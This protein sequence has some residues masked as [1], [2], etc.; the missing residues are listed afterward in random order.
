ME[1]GFQ[2]GNVCTSLLLL[3]ILRTLTGTLQSQSLSEREPEALP[4]PKTEA[5][6]DA[7]VME[8]ALENVGGEVTVED[9]EY[10]SSGDSEEPSGDRDTNFR[11]RRR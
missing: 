10:G 1:R 3:L 9:D 5:A 4:T 7:A 8:R 11:Q 2:F 6:E